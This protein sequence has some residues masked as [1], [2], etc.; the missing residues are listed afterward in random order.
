MLLKYLTQN[1]RMI[2]YFYKYFALQ[3]KR[4]ECMKRKIGYL[5]LV[6]LMVVMS[7][8]VSFADEGPLPIA[9]GGATGGGTGATTS[10]TG[11]HPPIDWTGGGKGASLPSGVG[12]MAANVFAAIKAA[13]FIVAV[14]LLVFFG[15]KYLTAGAGEKAKTKEMLVPFLIGVAILMLAPTLVEWIWGFLS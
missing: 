14:F 3:K 1:I 11:N 6:M 10:E 12:T 7:L 9:Y 5:F 4:G 15:I 13:C 2:K 8:T